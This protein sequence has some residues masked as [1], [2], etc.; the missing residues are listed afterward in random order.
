[1]AQYV[2]ADPERLERYDRSESNTSE[3]ERWQTIGKV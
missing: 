3:E 1:M 2:F